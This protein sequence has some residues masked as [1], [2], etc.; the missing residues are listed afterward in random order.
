VGCDLLGVWALAVPDYL[1]K[2]PTLLV[3]TISVM[4]TESLREKNPSDALIQF[5]AYHGLSLEDLLELEDE[6]IF[7]MV[8]CTVQLLLE[9]RSL[10]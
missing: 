6:V 8:G 7:D 9:I 1:W 10:R 2:V 4:T 3:L 5:L